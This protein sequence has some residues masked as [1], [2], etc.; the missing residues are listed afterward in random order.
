MWVAVV[1]PVFIPKTQ[2]DMIP[3]REQIREAERAL[4]ELVKG[5][6]EERKVETRRI[7]VEVIMREEH[8]EKLQ[9][10]DADVGNIDRDHMSGLE[11]Y[12][13][14]RTRE[15]ARIKRDQKERELRLS[16]RRRL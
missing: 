12:E 11:E 7:L 1:K 5:M 10:E 9:N 6:M 15:I 3:D 13:V 16:E 2:R 4:Q 8:I 14:W